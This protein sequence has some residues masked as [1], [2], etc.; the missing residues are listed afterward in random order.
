MSKYPYIPTPRSL[1]IVTA[2]DAVSQLY[3]GL[4]QASQ[5]DFIYS[6]NSPNMFMVTE[7]NAVYQYPVSVGTKS[8]VAGALF[9]AGS[10]DGTLTNARFQAL[11]VSSSQY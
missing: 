6:A 9:T 8:L 3:S 10:T 1:F 7:A 2:N 11:R 5:L 4:Q